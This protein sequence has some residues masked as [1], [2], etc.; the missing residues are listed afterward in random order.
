MLWLSEALLLISGAAL[1]R[2]PPG[3]CFPTC[4]GNF[5][6]DRQSGW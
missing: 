3:A 6:G 2:S 1:S 4:R 5:R